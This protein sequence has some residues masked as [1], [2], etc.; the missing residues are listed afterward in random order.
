VLIA[1]FFVFL[2]AL[3]IYILVKLWPSGGD[4]VKEGFSN[5]VIGKWTITADQQLLILVIVG[6]TL[7]GLARALLALTKYVGE[8]R[9][10]K[11][12]SYLTWPIIGAL[13]A[14]ILYIVIRAGFIGLNGTSEKTNAYGFL[15]VAL[16]G[17]LF[18][19]MAV[20]KLKAVA[21]AF[22]EESAKGDDA[23]LKPP[24]E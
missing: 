12:L 21:K 11:F 10:D 1:A 22:F 17:G 14:A 7:G 23:E 19:D 2:T 3:S 4:V 16:L 15:A 20:N 13:T 5:E 6:G 8:L 9:W 18:A 24:G